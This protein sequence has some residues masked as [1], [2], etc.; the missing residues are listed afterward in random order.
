MKKQFLIL[1][2]AVCMVVTACSSGLDQQ[3]GSDPAMTE[4]AYLEEA[5]RNIEGLETGAIPVFYTNNTYTSLYE[6]QREYD[7]T[8]MMPEEVL[9]TIVED[10]QN[11]GIVEEDEFE[12]ITIQSIIPDGVLESV[13][14]TSVEEKMVVEFRMTN[15]FYDMTLN[16]RIVM[17]AGLSR[18]I[19]STG[20]AEEII[21]MAPDLEGE[22]GEMVQINTSSVDDKLIINQYS[23]DF[24]TDEV[25]VTLYFSNADGTALVRETRSLTL[26]M[27]EPLPLA[28][29][30]ALIDGPETEGLTSVIPQGTVIE[31]IFIKDGVCYV[32]L[33]AEFQK[34]HIGGEQ[35]EKITIYSIVNSLQN[36]SGVR[37]VQ[38]LVE[39]KKVEYYKSYVKIDHFLTSNFEL[40]E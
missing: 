30:N 3:A 26:E 7:F 2:L 38:F 15:L 14:L 6:G 23:Q 16:Q 27:T 17:R 10:L 28:I 29:M 22:P 20:I 9:N 34:N 37:Y 11:T 21:F 40:V 36:V 4:S 33:S 5:T 18:T 35:E 39:G 13:V 1:L 24:Y 32:D 8:D 31:D 12:D 19:F 25:T